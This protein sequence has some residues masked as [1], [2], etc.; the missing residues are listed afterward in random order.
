MTPD[1]YATRS[2]A[3]EAIQRAIETIDDLPVDST[4]HEILDIERGKILASLQ[5]SSTSPSMAWDDRGTGSSIAPVNVSNFKWAFTLVILT[6]GVAASATVLTIGIKGAQEDSNQTFLHQAS[7]LVSVLELS[8]TRY[9]TLAL[10]IHE[11]CNYDSFANL[12]ILEDENASSKLS[13]AAG[14]CSRDKFK[15]LYEHISTLDHKVIAISYM[16]NITDTLRGALEEESRIAMKKHKPD[17]NY[18]GIRD[19]LSYPNATFKGIEPSPKRPFY[20]PIHYLEPMERNENAL[21]LDMYSFRRAEIDK[22]M[23]TMKPVMGPRGKLLQEDRPDVY[24]VELIHPGI[25]TSLPADLSA[26]SAVS[27]VVIRIPNLIERAATATSNTETSV[28][29]YDETNIRTATNDGKPVFLAAT[30][31]V[32][33][34]TN[35]VH[36]KLKREVAIDEI[37]YGEHSFTT[38]IQ[39]ADHTWRVIILGKETKNDVFFVT[40]GGAIILIGCIGVALGFHVNFKR[41]D[42]I[43]Q[44]KTSSETEKAELAMLQAKREMHLNDFIAHEVR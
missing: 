10:W 33:N 21:D 26:A 25:S 15:H 42:K 7:Q 28:Y 39:A 19:Y 6:L 14:F 35:G 11:A 20:F 44:I 2:D 34:E 17:F 32:Y 22:A 1:D 37:S 27:K 16:P 38:T 9:E 43:Q 4:D 40:I 30:D 36:T 13:S 8:W 24:A 41:L 29:I 3:P 12:T 31:V 5:S 18:S 23:A